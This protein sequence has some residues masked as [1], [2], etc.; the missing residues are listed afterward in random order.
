MNTSPFTYKSIKLLGR[1]ENVN[2]YVYGNID[3][4]DTVADYIYDY[5]NIFGH[6]V[7]GHENALGGSSKHRCLCNIYSYVN[8]SVYSR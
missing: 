7:R 4:V 8:G 2:V 5:V 3:D 6:L 1:A